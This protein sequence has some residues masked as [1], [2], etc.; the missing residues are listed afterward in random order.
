MPSAYV[1]TADG[2]PEVERFVDLPRPTPGD[3][4]LLIAVRAAGVNPADWKLRAGLRIPGSTVTLPAVFGLEAAGV[5][6]EVGP[7][8][9]GFAV[10]D[11]VFGGP[12]TGGYAEFTLLPAERAAH[13]PE[14]VSF[15]DAAALPVGAG[16][17]YDAIA[18]LALPPGATLLIIGVGGGVGV[19]AAQ[20]ARHAGLTVIG[21]A[22]P[23]KKAFVESL[24]VRHVASGPGGGAPR[25][26]GGPPPP[27]PASPVGFSWWPPGDTHGYSA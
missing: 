21:T 24:G 3:G 10:G 5:V 16:T 9:E 14:K 2:G 22:S 26:G 19:A 18:Q 13:K 4:E 27:P 17:A 12:T 25:G 15:T 7:G 8:V 11:E 6:V 23:R 1:F 20:L